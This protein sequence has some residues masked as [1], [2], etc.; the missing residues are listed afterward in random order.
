MTWKSH[1]AIATACVVPF[2]ALMLPVAV[3]GSVA[4]DLA[5]Y[6]INFFT[7][8]KIKHRGVTHYLFIPIL[9]IAFGKRS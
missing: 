9:I 2:N 1:I 8:K 3:A 4:P 6:V 7:K 5:E